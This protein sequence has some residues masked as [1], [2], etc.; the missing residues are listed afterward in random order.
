MLLPFSKLKGCRLKACDGPTGE[1]RDLYFNEQEWTI[2]YLIA[3]FRSWFTTRSVLL[4]V[5]FLDEVD[6]EAKAIAVSLK[7]LEIRRLAP[8]ELRKPVSAHER[9]KR[10][11]RAR[12]DPPPPASAA[13]L[14]SAPIDDAEPTARADGEAR[15]LRSCEE[16]SHGYTLRVRSGRIGFIEDFLIGSNDWCL[17]YIVIRTGL[18]FSGKVLLLPAHFVQEISFVRREVIASLPRSVIEEAPEYQVGV[19]LNGGHEQRLREH[20]ASRP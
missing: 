19:S 10:K 11:E 20:Y 17:R 8:A 16:I 13:P 4:P 5:Y 14:S 1:A 2:S 15:R 12:S 7:K 6:L 18:L 3:D 9:M